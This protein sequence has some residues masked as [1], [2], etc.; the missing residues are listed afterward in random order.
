MGF[1]CFSWFLTLLAG[2][3]WNIQPSAGGLVGQPLDLTAATASSSSSSLSPPP[4]PPPFRL[5]LVL[6]LF[7][8]PCSEW[9][10]Q[11]QRGRGPLRRTRGGNRW[12]NHPS[13]SSLSPIWGQWQVFLDFHHHSL[14]IT[15]QPSHCSYRIV[16]KRQ[17]PPW[18]KK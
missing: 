17:K 5:L 3:S 15:S 9:Q 1:C 13:F 6:L 2:A 18:P 7:S 12:K 16:S 11:S 14:L 4:P 8:A 10:Q